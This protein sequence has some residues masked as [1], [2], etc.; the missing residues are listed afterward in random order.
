VRFCVTIACAWV[1]CASRA[2]GQHGDDVVL[3]DPHPALD[4]QLGENAAGAR[5]DDDALVGLGAAGDRELAAVR[6]EVRGHGRD[7]EQLLRLAL[8]R[9]HGGAAFRALVRQEMAGRD[10]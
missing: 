9:A 5:G 6:D 7:A 4:P 10:P 3:L 2:V 8:A 1:T